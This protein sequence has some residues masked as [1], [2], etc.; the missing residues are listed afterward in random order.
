[1]EKTKIAIFGKTDLNSQIEFMEN[2]NKVFLSP[3]F[4][5]IINSLTEL[6]GIKKNKIPLE[7]EV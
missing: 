1:M 5:S 7:N 3:M 2:M 4:I 6:K